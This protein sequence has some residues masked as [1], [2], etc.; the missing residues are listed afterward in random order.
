[1]AH[2]M[3]GHKNIAVYSG[4]LY[5]WLGEGMPVIGSGEWEVWKLK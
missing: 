3:V 2:L 4:S 5:E 1:M